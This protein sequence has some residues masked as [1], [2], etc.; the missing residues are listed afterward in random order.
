VTNTPH[1]DP[2]SLRPSNDL[3]PRR[4][5]APGIEEEKVVC[6]G[7]PPSVLRTF[8]AGAQGANAE[9]LVENLGI[10]CNTL[11]RMGALT[12]ATVQRIA[13]D[14]AGI[15]ALVLAPLSRS[16][17]AQ[18]KPAGEERPSPVYPPIVI[19]AMIRSFGDI[20]A[21]AGE[22]YRELLDIRTGRLLTWVSTLR[23]ISDWNGPTDADRN[24]E[25]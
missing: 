21:V 17:L 24:N 19:D 16:P 8:D 23:T 15:A 3:L 6:F 13:Q 20:V 4:L 14:Q 11:W 5:N 2:V 1:T 9:L 18:A 7:V 25:G 10:N 22:S 12:F